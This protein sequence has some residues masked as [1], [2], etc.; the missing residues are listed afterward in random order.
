M[1]EQH[2]VHQTARDGRC[3]QTPYRFVVYDAHGTTGRNRRRAP[4]MESTVQGGD[5]KDSYLRI[6]DARDRQVKLRDER[7]RQVMKLNDYLRAKLADFLTNVDPITG[8]RLMEMGTEADR[9]GLGGMTF[10]LAVFEGSKLKIAVDPYGRFSHAAEPD[11]FAEVG[12]IERIRVATDMTRAEIE[13]FP[14]GSDGSGET[15]SIRVDG[16]LASLVRRAADALDAESPAS[17]GRAQ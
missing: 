3:E 13:Y 2:V 17:A 12:R 14:T 5:L 8:S 1:R 6:M 16:L 9:S 4:F 7:V 10:V 15:Q 11:V